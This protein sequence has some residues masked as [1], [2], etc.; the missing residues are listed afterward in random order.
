[1]VPTKPAVKIDPKPEP[2]QVEYTDRYKA[3]NKALLENSTMME[4][5][6]QWGI[7]DDA[8]THFLIGYNPQWVHPKCEKYNNAT[9]ESR[10]IFPRSR[11]T[12]SARVSDR[13][14]I[15]EG[16]Y[17]VVGKQKTLFNAEVLR[18]DDTQPIIVVEGEIDAILIWQTGN[19]VIGLGSTSNKDTFVEAAKA[20][21]SS[22][23]AV[24]RENGSS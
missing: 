12:Y 24:P 9:R 22:S 15:G 2:V 3:W 11:Y 23:A 21:I 13:A 5:L 10:S 14:Y 17:K 6:R 8:V 7:N 4:N 20:R 16:K 1:M 18:E 19:K